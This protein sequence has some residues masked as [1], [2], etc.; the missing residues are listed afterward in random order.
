MRTRSIRLTLQSAAT[1]TPSQDLLKRPL[2][3]SVTKSRHGL[4]I[5]E[6]LML[7]LTCGVIF[8]LLQPF[9]DISGRPS[10]GVTTTQLAHELPPLTCMAMSHDEKWIATGAPDGTTK[11]YS[12]ESGKCQSEF[13]QPHGIGRTMAFSPDGRNLLIGAEHGTLM[14]VDLHNRQNPPRL[15]PGLIKDLVH[16][17]FSP[18]GKW[19]LTSEV[20]SHCT[21]WEWKTWTRRQTLSKKSGYSV[22]CCCFD[23]SQ[24][25]IVLGDLHGQISVWDLEQQSWIVNERPEYARKFVFGPLAGVELL[26]N[27]DFISISQG[28]MVV[29]HPI[30]DPKTSQLINTLSPSIIVA[31]LSHDKSLVWTGK[32]NGEVLVYRLRDQKCMTQFVGHSGPVRGMV[33]TRDGKR[34]VTIG[35]D[36]EVRFWN[37]SLA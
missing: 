10:E 37:W 5:V 6:L 36:G 27:S 16:C 29:A 19:L 15:M 8:G 28:G 4:T 3:P 13:K 25:A 21:L 26:N 7:L 1:H 33:V 35:W 20:D 2:C 12:L 34:C 14:V 23:S 11:I 30:R 17:A 18:D 22:R 24:N 9:L 31:K 32:L